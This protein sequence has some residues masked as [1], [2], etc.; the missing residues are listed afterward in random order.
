MPKLFDRFDRRI[1]YI[2]VSVTDRCNYRCFYC[3]PGKN[4]VLEERAEFLSYEELTRLL[5]LFADLGV[6]RVRLSGAVALWEWR[7]DQTPDRVLL[8]RIA[9]RIAEP[10]RYTWGKTLSMSIEWG[11]R[12]PLRRFRKLLQDLWEEL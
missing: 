9:A 8:E 2:R 7:P 10:H 11:D 5:R 1:D 4:F 6:S 3:I 12:E